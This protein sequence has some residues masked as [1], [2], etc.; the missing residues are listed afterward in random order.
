MT[1][2]LNWITFWTLV[3]LL[4]SSCSNRIDPKRADLEVRELLRNVPGFDW[5]PQEKT[6][7][8]GV[9]QISSSPPP[10]MDDNQSRQITVR[11]QREDAY[12]DG[13]NSLNLENASWIS[14]LAVDSNNTVLLNLK[15]RWNSL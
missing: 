10:P 8:W 5:E 15:A 9:S 11:I 2:L 13:N 7:D 12:Q 3:I 6:L 1:I 4:T 14:S